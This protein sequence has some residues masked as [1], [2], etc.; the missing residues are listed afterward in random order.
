MSLGCP[1]C[2]SLIT[3]EHKDGCRYDLKARARPIHD[4]IAHI[5]A[6]AADPTI[7]GVLIE[8]ADLLAL[9]DAAEQS[10]PTR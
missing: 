5:R 6:V 4:I 10:V 1:G 2:R 8:T 3:D 9:C 7:K